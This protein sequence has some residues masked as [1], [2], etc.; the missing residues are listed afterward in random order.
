MKTNF[1]SFCALVLVAAA[2]YL[3]AEDAPKTAE[4][5][6]SSEFERLKSLVGAWQGKV[7][8]G[9]GPVD[10]IA[11]FRVLAGG[12]VIEE[13][14]F[15]GSPEEMVTMYYDKGGKLAL[16]HY[17]MLGN[18]PEMALK[19]SDAKS[20]S[21]D[22]DSCCGIDTAKEKHMHS[23]SIRFDDANT[24]TTGCTAMA[25]GKAAQMHDVVLKRVASN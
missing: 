10:M 14:V 22:F 20:I 23:L 3:R 5:P 18:R 12:N 4:T 21:F 15:P 1:I 2:P 9:H 6:K 8:I 11:Q 17:C 24:I 25:E 7:D 19:S 13:R 16:T